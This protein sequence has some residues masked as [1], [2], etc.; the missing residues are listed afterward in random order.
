[1]LQFGFPT[2]RFI[3]EVRPTDPSQCIQRGFTSSR[4]EKPCEKPSAGYGLGP[5]SFKNDGL[6]QLEKL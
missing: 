6:R 3:G 2:A 4:D 5:L 1:M